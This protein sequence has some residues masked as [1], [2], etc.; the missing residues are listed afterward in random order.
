MVQSWEFILAN[1]QTDFS[2]KFKR[3]I[4]NGR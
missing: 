2:Y 3:S 4:L 1:Y